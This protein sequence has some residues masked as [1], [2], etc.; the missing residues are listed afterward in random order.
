MRH[1][2]EKVENEPGIRRR[3]LRE[4]FWKQSTSELPMVVVSA[5]SILNYRGLIE[6]KDVQSEPCSV[7]TIS[8]RL[9]NSVSAE[10]VAEQTHVQTQ[11]T[12]E[13]K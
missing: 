7:T 3:V 12:R 5:D 11:K 13:Q 6:T 9:E 10:W 2:T 8:I 4:A 1:N